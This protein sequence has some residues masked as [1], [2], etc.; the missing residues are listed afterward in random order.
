MDRL[1]PMRRFITGSHALQDMCV[2]RL[3]QQNGRARVAA[4]VRFQCHIAEGLSV[5]VLEQR[6]VVDHGVDATK[7]LHHPG[8]QR[9]HRFLV[10]EICIKSGASPRYFFAGSYG[11]HSVIMRITVMHGHLPSRA[12]ESQ[13]H[14]TTQATGRTGHQY[15]A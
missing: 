8:H 3:G 9:A 14:V 13:G 11:L 6:G 1:E 10:K 7:A 12:G 2:Q 15:C 5:V 4:Q